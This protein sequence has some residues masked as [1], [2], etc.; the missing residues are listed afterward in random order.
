MSTAYDD[1]CSSNIN[2]TVEENSLD[3]LSN[4]SIVIDE[5]CENTKKKNKEEKILNETIKTYNKKPKP[6]NQLEKLKKKLVELY[7]DNC[8]AFFKDL[9]K[10]WKQT[11][12]LL[13]LPP[14]CFLS[15]Y[16]QDGLINKTANEKSLSYLWN[17]VAE[18]FKVNRIA[19][20]NRVKA[21][22]F[23]TPRVKLVY[24]DN[25][26]VTIKNNGIV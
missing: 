3:E 12:D 13:I 1:S 9:P 11:N 6:L 16:W 25:S 20:E 14:D 4:S 8:S 19:Q 17:A 26:I 18:S 10:K 7:D 22:S 15:S 23:R 5:E 2:Y 21:D 24:G